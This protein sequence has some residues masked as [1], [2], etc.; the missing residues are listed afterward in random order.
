M[1]KQGQENLDVTGKK[2]LAVKND[3]GGVR[4]VVTLLKVRFEN[5]FSAY[6]SFGPLRRT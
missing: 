2:D 1:R 5:S 4:D 6:A 3:F